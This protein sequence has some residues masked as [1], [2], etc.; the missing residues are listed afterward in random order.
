MHAQVASGGA[1]LLER[2][3]ELALIEDRIGAAT[4]A[5][6]SL[7]LIEGPAGIGKTELVNAARERAA[8]AGMEVLSARG[9]ELERS[10][11]LG[12]VRQLFEARLAAAP[13]A[14]RRKLLAGAASLAASALG[15]EPAHAGAPH[16]RPCR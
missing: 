4:E 10:L 6:G 15:S 2:Q 7:L 16:R 12:I 1:R 9:G 11:G 14:E 5:R 8:A 13:A 3:S